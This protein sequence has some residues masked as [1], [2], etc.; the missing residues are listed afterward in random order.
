MTWVRIKARCYNEKHPKYPSYGGRGITVCSRWRNSFQNFLA[1][2]GL[3]PSIEHSLDRYP[4]N[5]GHYE[6]GNVRWATDREQS[7]NTR[8]NNVI[9]FLGKTFTLAELS[10]E[11]GIDYY[12]LRDRLKKW[13]VWKAVVTP[14]KKCGNYR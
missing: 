10:S 9:E 7:N 8:R 3:A 6:P 11:T 14:V 5:N 4:N 1:D 12:T 2:V 13:S